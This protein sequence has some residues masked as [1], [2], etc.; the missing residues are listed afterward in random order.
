MAAVPEPA[1]LRRTLTDHLPDMVERLEALVSCE[2]P[3]SDASALSRCAE[4]LDRQASALWGVR[5]EWASSDGRP[6][7]CWQFGSETKVLV[8]GHLDTVWPMGTLA[9][10]PFRVD[11]SVATGPGCFDMKAGLVQGMYAVASLPE[12]SGVTVLVTSDEEVG[13]PTSRGLIERLA[14]TARAAL[15]LEPSTDGALKTGRKGISRYEV[16]VTGRAAHAGLE[17]EAGANAALELAE[18]ALAIEALADSGQGTSV[19]PTTMSAGTSS[20]T[21]PAAARM[22]VD[23][24]VTSEAEQLRV[25]A[26]MRALTPRRSG[27]GIRLLGGPNRPPLPE[28]ASRDLLAH[29]RRCCDRLGLPL[30]EGVTVG[31]ASDGNITAALG[32]PTLDGLGAVGHGAHAA[33]ES[34]VLDDMPDRAAL[35]AVLVADLL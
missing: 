12:R 6:H 35:L 18:Q 32:V 20:N 26:A 7:L 4:L 27:T 19:T 16:E 2:S 21:V 13:S 28:A 30:V 23:V 29:A 17:P 34:V 1:E 24:R 10:W 3:S 8:L 9:D 5:P 15:V 31:G 14:R 22:E 33:G 11:G 25:D